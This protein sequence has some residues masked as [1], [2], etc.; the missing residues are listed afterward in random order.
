LPID[1]VLRSTGARLAHWRP[2]FLARPFS[3]LAGRRRVLLLSQPETIPQSQIFPFHFYA[4]DLRDRRRV[5]LRELSTFE[6]E[7]RPDS[8]PGP[9]DVVCVQTWFNLTA[10]RCDR[11]FAAIRQRHPAAKVVF[12]DWYAPTDLR[13][14]AML[15]AHVD[16]YVKKHVFRD[17]TRYGQSTFG[18][19]NLVDYYSR[20]YGLEQPVTRFEVSA[21]MLRKLQVGPTFFTSSLM[22]PHFH[23][24]P[25]PPAGSRTFDLHAR[26][27]S[28]GGG[29]YQAMR[30][31][32][33]AAVEHLVALRA[34]T[35]FGVSHWRY[36]S[37]LRASKLCFSPF[38]YGE[39]CW[40]DYEAVMCGSILV[41]PDMSHVETAPDIFQSNLTYLSVAWDFS[42]LADKVDYALRNERAMQRMAQGAHDVLRRHVRDGACIE[43]LAEI[44]S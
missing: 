19:T 14:A 32:A 8:A 11:L 12:L 16:L 37:E 40:R 7:Q 26:L 28:S 15:D 44:V 1:T 5:E 4:R 39:V 42:D 23:A 18:D 9:A 13:L 29:W 17:R 43:Q 2:R 22:L 36:L 35:G 3:S 10:A 41:K 25:A 20:L 31:R 6:F 24:R 34:V 33:A 21:S 38:G 27:G 30:D